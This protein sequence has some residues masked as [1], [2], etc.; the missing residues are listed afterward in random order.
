MAR[1]GGR[2][3][4]KKT[5][6]TTKGGGYEDTELKQQGYIGTSGWREGSP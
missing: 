2:E 5:K 6:E 1:R 3:E 4:E